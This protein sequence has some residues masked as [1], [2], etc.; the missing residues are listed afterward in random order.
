S[1]TTEHATSG[2]HIRG[3][4]ALEH[5][6]AHMAALP[7]KT[8]ALAAQLSHEGHWTFTNRAGERFTAATPDEMKRAIT[9]LA[10][11][12]AKA[13][14]AESKLTLYLTEDSL[15]QDRTRFKDLPAQAELRVMTEKASQRL[16]TVADGAALKIY[17]ELRP[18]LLIEATDAARYSEAVYQLNRS[19]AQSRI[20][21][22]SLDPQ[23]PPTL[24]SGPRLD[25]ATG[26]AL[27]DTITPDKLVSA[28][29]ALRRQTALLVAR[30]EADQLVFRP[31]S[32][33]ERKI[34][35]T[36][37]VAEVERWDVN[38]LIINAATPNQ[39]GA[40]NW[41]W[42][43]VG[44]K[45]LDDAL[46]NAT[47]ADIT[48]AL[49]PR[50][51]R[52]VA[53]A[54]PRG[55]HQT[56]LDIEPARGLPATTSTVSQLGDKVVDLVSDLTGG[57]INVGV[58]AMLTSEARQREL[59]DR[60]I[61]GLPSSIQWSYIVA[62]LLGMFGAPVAARWWQQLWPQEAR[63]QYAGAGGYWAARSVRA[64]AFW[65]LFVP[66]VAV[67]TAPRHLAT[68]LKD[69]ATAPIRAWRWVRKRNKARS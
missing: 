51:A 5:A 25:P 66:V 44:V 54:T 16:V 35:W 46:T 17:T 63:E 40:R 23:G 1:R 7:G 34:P 56:T 65:L 45:G 20:R 30:R 64:A 29:G 60:I 12:S 4:T 31:S 43:K 61:P 28:L 69:L 59:T 27:I 41:L 15:F 19:L 62:L 9:T 53:S 67:G 37:V 58:H 52:H 3:A 13:S 48:S 2:R 6:A 10:P 8:P 49:L 24:T 47:L 42:Q 55:L 22:L 36:T 14:N 38:L 50:N 18:N 33:A 68:R 26:R 32:G 57:I 21:V 11:D 39:P